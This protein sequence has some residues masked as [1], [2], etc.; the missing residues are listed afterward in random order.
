MLRDNL[1]TASLGDRR[2][3][4]YTTNIYLKKCERN[5]VQKLA[6]GRE[7]EGGYTFAKDRYC[8][9]LWKSHGPS[10]SHETTARVINHLSTYTNYTCQP[11]V[12][13]RHVPIMHPN[14]LINTCSYIISLRGCFGGERSWCFGGERSSRILLRATISVCLVNHIVCSLTIKGDKECN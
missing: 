13:T 3:G 14:H 11:K 1:K 9:A 8:E 2:A 6:E 5:K 4:K 7:R 12:W 10:H